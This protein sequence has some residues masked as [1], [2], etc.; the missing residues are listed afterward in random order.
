MTVF[1]GYE[2]MTLGGF[3]FISM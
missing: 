2:G 1:G 3:V